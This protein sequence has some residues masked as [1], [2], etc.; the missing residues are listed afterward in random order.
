MDLRQVLQT[1]LLLGLAVSQ[2]MA[3]FIIIRALAYIY[4]EEI[5]YDLATETRECS[6]LISLWCPFGP[7]SIAAVVWVALKSSPCL[8]LPLLFTL[9]FTYIE[10]CLRETSNLNLLPDLLIVGFDGLYDPRVWLGLALDS[11]IL[12]REC[13]TLCKSHSRV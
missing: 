3:R 7:P 6:L 4:L 10:D 12:F 2:K 9:G 8:F 5:V 11:P 1:N 13:Q